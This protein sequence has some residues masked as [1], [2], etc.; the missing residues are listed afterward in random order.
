MLI[1]SKT[2][3]RYYAWG[4]AL[5]GNWGWIIGDGAA[6]FGYQNPL[7]AYALSNVDELKPKGRPKLDS[8]RSL[9]KFCPCIKFPYK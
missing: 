5:N 7:T 6:H 4:A 9:F 1:K 2:L 8:K 3:L